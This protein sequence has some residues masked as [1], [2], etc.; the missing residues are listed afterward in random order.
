MNI[1]YKLRLYLKVMARLNA[2]S[3]YGC[4]ETP[5]TAVQMLY[6]SSAPA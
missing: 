1:I 2:D 6:K 5:P 4:A 3:S